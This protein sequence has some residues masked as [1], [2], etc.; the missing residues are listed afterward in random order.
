[1]QAEREVVRF[2]SSYQTIWHAHFPSLF[3]RAQWHIVTHLCTSG[4]DGAAVGEL[5][6]LVKQVF[7]LDDSTVKERI[8]E[9]QEL[10]LCAIDP[11]GGTLSARSV[12]V[13][14]AALFDLFDRHLLALAKE[15]ATAATALDP[16]VRLVPP[17][18]LDAQQRGIIL[19]AL[20]RCREPWRQALDH[21]FDAI[22]LSRARRVEAIRH[23]NSMSHWSLLHMAVELHYGVSTF[24]GSEQGILADQMAA[25]LLNLTGQNFQ[26]TRDHIAYLIALG[27]LERQAGK[28][29]RVALA[30]SAIEPFHQALGVAAAA[31]P[32]VARSLSATMPEVPA[33]TGEDAS[34]EATLNLRPGLGLRRA[35]MEPQHHL[36][37]LQPESS[38][39]RV[40]LPAGALTIGRA[41]PSTLLLEGAE[42]SRAHCRI[43]V[44]G[45]EVNITDLNS[46]NG[47]FVDNKRLSA[48]APLPHGAMLRVGNYVMTCEYQ[49]VLRSEEADSTQRK[50]GAFG[51]VT[52][53]RPR[54]GKS[55]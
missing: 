39:R 49:S 19:Q 43:D 52:M 54:R 45:D 10:K 42:V 30:E 33:E 48:T 41:P 20:N 1:M 34:T 53:L 4:R 44:E 8:L 7:L 46:T 26:T 21:I 9:I 2:L 5:Y 11:P 24:A 51:G 6:G 18:R 14:T 22:D 27:L 36:I 25:S 37:I 28:S 35:A 16:S 3:R 40:A 32:E 15:L 50:V 17:R 47:T 38:V 23:L 55:S 31:L 13:P 12:V 29:L